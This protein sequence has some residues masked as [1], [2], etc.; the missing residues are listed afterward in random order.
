MKA[1]IVQI[2]VELATLKKRDLSTVDFFRKITGLATKLTAADAP[3]LDEEV[4]AYMLAGLPATYD[5]FITLMMTKTE[6]LSLDT[7]FAHL[8]AFEAHKL[9]H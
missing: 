1:L 7:V 9:Q 3:L 8:V 2:C 5:P 4:L 6:P